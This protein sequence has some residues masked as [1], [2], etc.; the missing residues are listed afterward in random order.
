MDNNNF[1]YTSPRI[2]EIEYERDRLMSSQ[3]YINFDNIN[4]SSQIEWKEI[5]KNKKS[6]SIKDHFLKNKL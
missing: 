6:K 4:K 1:G 3:A 2:M 5:E